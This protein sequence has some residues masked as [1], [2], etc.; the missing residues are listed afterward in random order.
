MAGQLRFKTFY[1]WRKAGWEVKAT[2]R[3]KRTEEGKL[4]VY[5]AKHKKSKKKSFSFLF[6]CHFYFI[7]SDGS[8]FGSAYLQIERSKFFACAT[9]A[10]ENKAC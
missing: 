4:L 10:L 3:K 5:S 6:S 9:F 7:L 8:G 1:F 2:G